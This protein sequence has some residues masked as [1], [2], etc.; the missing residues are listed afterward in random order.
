MRF[1]RG[2]REIGGNCVELRHRQDTLILDIGN[3]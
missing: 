1:H 3:P 2:A